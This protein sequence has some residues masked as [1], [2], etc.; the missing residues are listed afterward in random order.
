VNGYTYQIQPIKTEEK[1][2]MTNLQSKKVDLQINTNIDFT[3]N[4]NLG[5]NLGKRGGGGY[6]VTGNYYNCRYDKCNYCN[7][8]SLGFSPKPP[9]GFFGLFGF[10]LVELL[11]VIAV[12][13]ML[14]ALLLPAVQSAREAARRMS[15]TNNLKQ[16]GLAVHTFHDAM[17]GI[18][19]ANIGAGIGP[20]DIYHAANYGWSDDERYR[21]ASIWPLLYPY[22]EQQP[23]YDQYANASFDGRTGFNVRLTNKWWNSFS[24]DQKKQ[25]SSVPVTICPSRGR[26]SRIAE[27]GR[28]DTEGDGQTMVSGPV[29]DYA[30][31]FSFISPDVADYNS[32]GVWWHV[33]NWSAKTNSNQHGPFR[34]A[35]L[36]ARQTAGDRDGNTWQPQDDFNRFADGASN[37]LLF[38]EKHIP[39]SRIGR[40]PS[41]AWTGDSGSTVDGYG[42]E[43]LDIGDCSILVIGEYRAP[44][45]ARVVRHHVSSSWPTSV[46]PVSVK[47]AQP[48]IITPNIDGY[49][50]HRYSAFGGIHNGVCNFLIGDGSIHGIPASIN[51]GILAAL[52]TVDD[53]V[54]ASLP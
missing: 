8:N 9:S 52:G 11:V 22:M 49:V 6:L 44:S 4:V 26:S 27:S 5:V 19:P 10:T 54:P 38:G 18:P 17:Q 41:T 37:Q 3:T 12:I 14:I 15:C 43:S 39:Q 33:G 1:M 23:L 48:G 34:A 21:R 50:A 20:Y 47:D 51:P 53:G 35:A 45:T 2:K 30:M 36:A 24:A 32:E 25:H 7:D 13:G 46:F 42:L 16:I 29:G 28:D 31:V 40:C